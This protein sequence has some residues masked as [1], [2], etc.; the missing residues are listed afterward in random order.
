MNQHAYSKA[1]PPMANDAFLA[2]AEDIRVSGLKESIVTLEGQVLDGWMRFLACQSVGVETRFRTYQ[3]SDPKGYV[4][5]KNLFR[6]NMTPYLTVNV[7]LYLGEL[8]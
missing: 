3:G 6:R 8:A 4:R 5:S 2:L 1:F 7:E